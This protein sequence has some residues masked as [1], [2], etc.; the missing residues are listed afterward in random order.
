[1]FGQKRLKS[2][3]TQAPPERNTAATPDE[4]MPESAEGARS[5]VDRFRDDWDR[6]GSEFRDRQQ[7]CIAELVGHCE[8]LQQ[9]RREQ[10]KTLETLE[11]E[12]AQLRQQWDQLAEDTAQLR[13]QRD[14]L[15]SEADELRNQRQRSGTD[16]AQL[17]Q[18]RDQ[19][20]DD[21]AQL[22]QERDQL[23]HEAALLREQR[24]QL[25]D[26]AAQLRRDRDRLAGELAH[27]SEQ[28]DRLAPEAQRQ[29]DRPDDTFDPA[30]LQNDDAP[31]SPEKAPQLIEQQ[32]EFPEDRVHEL[33]ASVDDQDYYSEDP[34]HEPAEPVAAREQHHERARSRSRIWKEIVAGNRERAGT[35]KARAADAQPFQPKKPRPMPRYVQGAR[36][37]VIR[38]NDPN[39]AGIDARLHE[40]SCTGASL[41]LPMPLKVDEYV[42]IEMASASERVQVEVR[43]F[44][45]QIEPLVEGNYLVGFSLITQLEFGEVQ[46]LRFQ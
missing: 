45:R 6:I 8:R 44:V 43:A 36:A 35:G 16:A 13:Q 30:D 42:V 3:A 33:A 20:A 1:M 25:A 28:R 27:S 11:L 23:A 10:A 39:Q 31:E 29:D 32:D 7:Q 21:A 22:R 41:I 17:R 18:E 40:V 4:P 2:G 34:D 38:D 37:T 14:Q 46:G 26:E 5:V 19:L 12:A 9:R 24:D 15:A